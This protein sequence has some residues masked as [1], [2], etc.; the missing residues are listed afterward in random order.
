MKKK[1]RILAA[2]DFHGNKDIAR[3]LA[4]I[5][6]KEDVELVILN[7]DIV[8]DHEPHGIVGYF[9]NK[10]KRVILIPG[11]HESVSTIEMLANMYKATNLHNVYYVILG[12]VG[13]FGSAGVTIGLSGLPEEQ[14]F[15]N[16][17]KGF[18]KIKHLPTKIMVTH[19]HPSGTLM[20]KFSQFVRGSDGVR[21][22]ID[23]LKPDIAICGHVHE[24]EGIEEKLGNTTLINVGKSGKIIEV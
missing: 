6:E 1:I 22:A 13:I 9:I 14:I 24:A 5:A 20:E 17:K 11:N 15:E 21:K 8:E 3:K 18:E 12:D 7:G 2:G 16:L 4:N 19:G 23:V 10:N